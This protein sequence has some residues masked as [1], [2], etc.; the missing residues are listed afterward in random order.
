MAK[1]GFCYLLKKN[2]SDPPNTE[3][4]QKLIVAPQYN[5]NQDRTY[6]NLL[7]ILG[8]NLSHILSKSAQLLLCHF[9]LWSNRG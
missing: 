4:Y 9:I 7:N 6:L 1:Q 2:F 8:Q 5:C 3:L